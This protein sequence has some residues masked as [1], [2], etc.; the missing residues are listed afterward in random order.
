VFEQ[1]R[2]S[3]REILASRLAPDDRRAVLGQMKDTLVR[4]RIGVDD[5]RHGVESTRK[6]V[7]HEREELSTVRRRREL[8][9]RIK[10]A[11][12]VAV[13]GRYEEQV[14]ERLRVMEQ[15]L[16][17][18]EAELELLEREV[19]EMSEEFRKAANGIGVAPESM[20]DTAAREAERVADGGAEHLR[21]EFDAMSRAAERSRREAEA[22][23]KLAALKRRMG[24]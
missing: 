1:V 11:E 17:A 19:A 21:S 12:T 7:E 16:A 20:E 3:F 18:Q 5:V 14:A 24:K 10:D 15:K 22:D 2:Q 13:A 4:A 23:E 9:E 8:A 6:R